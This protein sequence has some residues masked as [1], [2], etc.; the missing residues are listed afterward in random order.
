[1]ESPF[2]VSLHYAFQTEAKL[3][4]VLDYCP[5]GELFYY[6]LNKK[7]LNEKEAALIIK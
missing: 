4:F 2:I 1:M 5:G 7:Q 6:I 3:F